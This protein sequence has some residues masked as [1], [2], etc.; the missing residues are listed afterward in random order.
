[1]TN[2]RDEVDGSTP[3]GAGRS[4]APE[5]SAAAGPAASPAA[6]AA[7]DTSAAVDEGR[8]VRVRVH[9]STRLDAD[10]DVT[11]DPGSEAV[12]LRWL[13]SGHATSGTGASTHHILVGPAGPLGPTGRREREIVVDG[14]RF[15]LEVEPER[16]ARLREKAVRGRARGSHG[17]PLEVRAIIPG[18]VVAV[19]VAVG[20]EVEAGHQL[21]VIEAMKMQNEL[22]AP[23]AGVVERIAV[24]PGQTVDLGTLLLVLR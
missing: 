3:G 18:R 10:E 17:G 20:D 11:V 24:G 1:M 7:T 15:V 6:S 4:A 13:D 14:W 16:L 21:L 8:A 2:L 12:A 22:R 9:A 5:D 23:R 19:S